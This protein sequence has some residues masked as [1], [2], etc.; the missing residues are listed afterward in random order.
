MLLTVN[1]KNHRQRIS[2]K[3]D[4]FRV[5]GE[6]GTI[7]LFSLAVPMLF[8][9]IA[10]NMIGFA[11]SY[12]LSGFSEEAVAAA[13][14]A[15][16]LIN[17]FNIAVSVIS[18]GGSVVVSKLIGAGNLE[19]AEKAAFSAFIVCCTV[20]VFLSFLSL[21]LGGIFMEWMN[22]DG[23]VWRQ[24][25]AYFRIRMG[26]FCVNA[27]SL[28]L[29]ALI[30]CYGYSLLTVISNLTVLVTTLILNI[31][32][33]RFPRFFPIAGIEGVATGSV[34]GVALGMIL[35]IV[36]IKSKKIGFSVPDSFKEGALYIKKV[37]GI[38][39]PSAVS[40]LG[41]SL[42]QVIMTSFVALIGVYAVSAKVYFTNILMFSYL[43]SVCFGNANS[44]LIGRLVGS[45][46]FGHA[47]RLNRA[48]VR[49]TCS[50]N[51]SVSLLIV[52]LRVPLI[53]IFTDNPLIIAASFSVFFIDMIAE[54]A[55]G[56]SQ[57]YEYALR[58]A[59][60]VK[61]MMVITT[62]SSW[63]FGVGLSYLLAIPLGM[64]LTGCWIGTSTDECI[65]AA[66]A[67]YRWRSGMWKAQV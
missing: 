31:L 16:T 53:S 39:V 14:S 17:L 42:S 3:T 24:A 35:N 57:V 43:F 21:V 52:V 20:G 54:Q 25:T 9:N 4:L 36:F 67:I 40:T 29:S 26:F 32:V 56:I 45:G 28:V 33:I 63:A 7:S 50:V 19:K 61:F 2:N 51:L 64:G 55:R 34:I 22:L 48:L 41:Y 13:G 38:G 8:E 66:A 27:I 47:E 65:R 11:N 18:V 6:L 10:N 30:R 1:F 59:G 44:I 46:D 62:V 60:D 12:V 58:G 23:E 37:L 5:K 15:T 49:F